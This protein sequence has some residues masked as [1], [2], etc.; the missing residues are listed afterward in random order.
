MNLLRKN[1]C[2]ATKKSGKPK[3]YGSKQSP[4][5]Q[6]KRCHRELSISYG[7]EN[8]LPHHECS[9]MQ[10]KGHASKK[11]QQHQF[12]LWFMSFIKRG[13]FYQYP[14]RF[15]AWSP[16]LSCYISSQVVSLTAKLMI[17]KSSFSFHKQ[18]HIR[19]HAC[20]YLHLAIALTHK[21][22]STPISISALI[23][24]FYVLQ[25]LNV[26]LVVSKQSYS[27]VDFII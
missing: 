17:F 13:F 15:S 9:D 16:S 19:R 26:Y 14:S 23:S 27:M 25:S 12:I 8:D 18:M 2:A 22:I 24:I 1:N 21:L 4:V 5:I 11:R 10:K 20:P 3:R 6:R 7:D